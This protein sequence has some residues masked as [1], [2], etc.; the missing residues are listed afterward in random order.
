MRITDRYQGTMERVGPAGARPVDKAAAVESNARTRGKAAGGAL[1]VTVS[2][3]AQ[4]L[5]SGAARLDELR[6][7]IRDGSFRVDSQRIAER[8]VGLLGTEDGG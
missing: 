6:S 2:D 4:E 7:A 5:A 1:E 3:R 8:L